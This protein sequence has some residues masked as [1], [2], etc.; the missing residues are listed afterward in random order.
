MVLLSEDIQSI[1][2]PSPWSRV[3]A[4][5]LY[6]CI[7]SLETA[8]SEPSNGIN[9]ERADS[10]MH[11]PFWKLQIPLLRLQHCR[12]RCRHEEAMSSR[13][14]VCLIRDNNRMKTCPGLTSTNTPSLCS[15]DHFSLFSSYAAE[16]L[17]NIRHNMA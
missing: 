1:P 8:H 5:I 4:C 12:T 6:R 13:Q 9:Y 16:K 17:H 15:T 2:G 7:S 3:S 10:Y 14:Y 11:H